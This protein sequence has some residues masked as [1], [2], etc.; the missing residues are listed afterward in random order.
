MKVA[1]VMILSVLVAIFDT[2]KNKNNTLYSNVSFWRKVM[3]K[4]S[5]MFIGGGIMITTLAVL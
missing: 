2:L 4:A 3:N 5:F 1:V